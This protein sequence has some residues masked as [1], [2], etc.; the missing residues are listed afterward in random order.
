VLQD[1]LL[2]LRTF[3]R[4]PLLAVTAILCLALGIGGTTAVFSV[5]NGV[6]LQPL[7]YPNA[8]RLVTMRPTHPDNPADEGRLSEAELRDWQTMVRSFDA[9]AGYRW[10]TMDLV[11]SEQSNRIQGLWVTPEFFSVFGIEASAGHVLRTSDPPGI[12]LGHSVWQRRFASN[13]AIVGQSVAVGICCPQQPQINHIPVAGAVGHD[14]AYPPTLPGIRD[15][16]HGL[17]ETIDYWFPLYIRDAKRPGA[18]NIEAVARLKAGVTLEQ[19]QTE[20]DAIADRLAKDFPDSNR[21]WRVRVTSVSDELFANVR[22]VLY[23]LLAAAGFVLLIACAN[24]AVLLTFHAVQRFHEVAIRAALGASIGRLVRQSVVEGLVLTAFGG[25]AGLLV[26]VGVRRVLVTFAPAG[27][28]RVAEISTDL[29]VFGFAAILALA[30][31]VFIGLVP[32]LRI[33]KF[34]LEPTLRGENSR[35]STS[36]VRARTFEPLLVLQVALTLAL[37]IGSGLMFKTLNHLLGVAPG[38]ER[39]DVIITT[40]SLPSAKHAWNYNSR[41]IENVLDRV[42]PLPGVVAAGA[43]RG[44][45]LNETR[46]DERFWRWDKPPSDT[47]RATLGAIRVVS[48]GYLN[49][50]GLPLNAG[51]DFV[52]QDGVGI[53]GTTRAVMINETMARLLWPG[54]NAVG[55]KLACCNLENEG[56]TV[57]GVVGDVR[58][59]SLDRPPVPEV[60]YPEGVFPQD[61]IALVVRTGTNAPPIE[62]IRST[63]HDIEHDVFIGP[64][65]S[66]D[67]VM[68]RSAAQ[69]RF[70]MWLLSMFSGTG[71]LLAIA[72]IMGAVAYSLSLRVNEVGIRVAM[73]ATP[74]DVVTLIARQGVLPALAGIVLGSVVALALTRFLSAMLFAVDPDDPQVFASAIA[75]LSVVCILAAGIPAYRACHIDPS[76]ILK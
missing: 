27:L 16:G 47:S 73:G 10:M 54:E 37:L 59:A 32:A 50:M 65:Q 74:R 14:I 57:I 76:R 5:I 49:A 22:P 31:G 6:L 26:A 64:F 9:I 3:R 34:D 44:V 15:P 63:I 38:F 41:F 69:R 21:G 58:Y 7:P 39:S 20:M 4:N 52:R 23:L 29:R 24:V 48:E 45:P 55:Q 71:V 75:A 46:F 62:S 19:A 12:V 42:R 8:G 17:N 53:V 13:P 2:A 51:R 1:F 36:H 18:R 33:L 43:I 56:A 11:D 72:G 28:P 70:I 35:N 66:M 40:L 30:G 61:E 68:E 25:A 60:Y 67:V